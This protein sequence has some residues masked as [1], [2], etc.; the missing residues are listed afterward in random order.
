MEPAST[1]KTVI[2]IVDGENYTVRKKGRPR[3][4]LNKI[5]PAINKVY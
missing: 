3:G 1:Q 5:K 4:S 2:L